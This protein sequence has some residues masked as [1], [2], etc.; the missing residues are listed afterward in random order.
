MVLR[1]HEDES[2]DFEALSYAWGSDE[3]T[4]HVYVSADRKRALTITRNLDTA[5]R[6]LRHMDKPCEIWVDALCIDQK[7][8]EEKNH[9]V[10]L[11]S[12][13]YTQASSV[14]I[15]LGPEKDQSNDALKLMEKICEEVEADW[16]ME[17]LRPSKACSSKDWA[18]YFVPLPYMDGE[19]I[20]VADLFARP[21]FKR[22]WIRQE[23]ILANKA[24]VYCG[25][26]SIPWEDFRTASVCLRA[27]PC[28][29]EAIGT[30]RR[31]EF[32]KS[33]IHV[34][35]LCRLLGW[36][37]K[38]ST[39]R[40]LQGVAQCKDPRDRIY[41]FLGLLDWSDRLLNIIPDYDLPV[42]QL[43]TMWRDEY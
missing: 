27:K 6:H 23:I 22:A 30:I 13:I 15:W 2:L 16:G 17:D 25:S 20:P 11:M 36:K 18:D 38:L 19:L 32:S 29:L 41:S 26:V 34:F 9:Q 12:E 8:V 7:S 42:E 10:A 39:L 33:R 21:Y 40:D 24:T 1:P 37:F 14:M 4:S 28:K 43:F 5:L 35:N 3:D 31:S